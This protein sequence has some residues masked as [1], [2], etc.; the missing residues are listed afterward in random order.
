MAD[1]RP[2]ASR[3]TGGRRSPTGRCPATSAGTTSLYWDQGDYRGVGSAAHSH[4][5]GQRWWNV[6]TPDRYV[7]LIA[8]GRSPGGGR[9]GAR[10]RRAARSRPWP[11]RCARPT[12]CPTGRLPDDPSLGRPGDERRG[13]RAVLTVRGRLLANARDAPAAR[14][15]PPGRSVEGHPVTC[16]A[17]RAHPDGTDAPATAARGPDGEGGRPVQAAR[18]SSSRRPRSTAASAR[19][20]TTARSGV[21]LLRN[22]KNAWW[23]SM[24]QLRDD[25][26]GLDAAIL[27]P[28]AVWEASGHLANF[29]DPLVDCRSAS[30]AGG[31]TRSTGSARTAGRTDFTEARAFNLMFKTHA[32][33]VEDEGAVAYLR[34]ETAQGMFINF[35]NVLQTTRKKPPFG[36]A[37]VGQVVPQRDHPAELR[38]P[39]PR[40]RADGDRV[41]RAARPT[42]SGGS[43]TGSTSGSRWYLDLG[44]P[45]TAPAPAPPRRRRALPLLGGHRRRGVRSSRGAGTSSRASPTAP[46]ST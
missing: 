8:A 30:S 17:D 36:I 38:V 39:H 7:A 22:V 27:S 5:A 34:P 2:G 43:S 11:S 24:V 28:P 23:R 3:A 33:P 35:A 21:N 44:I 42:P 41:L 6:R 12:G 4:R 19:P 10:R 37:Q 15:V 13:G 40:V 32:G 45:E 29:T 16:A 46:T 14:P 26:V 20:T 18:A 31:P 25:V 1:A 9:R